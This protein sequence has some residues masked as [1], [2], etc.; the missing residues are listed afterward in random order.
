[1]IV[2]PKSS[3]DPSDYYKF[4]SQQALTVD[5]TVRTPT[6]PTGC[7]MAHVFFRKG[8]V[9]MTMNG[10]D[11]VALTTGLTLFDG[12]E[13]FYSHLELAVMKFI[14]EDTDDGEVHLFYYQ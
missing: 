13:E 12:Y 8:T 6:V 7:R 1:M 9:R 14:K 2:Q 4:M 10:V 3:A 11:P 5:G